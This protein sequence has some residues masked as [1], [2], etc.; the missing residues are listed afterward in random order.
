MPA[1]EIAAAER[2]SESKS[3]E[4]AASVP[5]VQT[6][7]GAGEPRLAGG[8]ADST[9]RMV[10]NVALR[11]PNAAVM[12]ASAMRQAQRSFGNRAMQEALSDKPRAAR[13]IQRSCAC[14]G[15]CDS[16]QAAAVEPV[17][18][19]QRK[20]I[21]A[22]G[23]EVDRSLIPDTPGQ[24][25][26]RNSQQLLQA[27]MG[28]D[29]S[30]VRV[31]ADARAADSAAALQA[32]AYT[33]GRDIYFGAGKYSPG[34]SEGT[35]LIAHEVTH[36]LQQSE[37]KA[38]TAPALHGS[39]M[40]GDVND[41]MEREAEQVADAV[42]ARSAMPES[43]IT[44]DGEPA[45]RRDFS[46]AGAW[47]ATGGRAWSG[48]K[49][50]A[51]AVGNAAGDLWD[52][53][54]DTAASFIDTIAPGLLPFLRDVGGA[55]FDKITS[56][57]GSLMGGLSERIKNQGV[58]GAI[59]GIFADLASSLGK[60]IGQ[61]VT[62]SCQS[63]VAAA[64][65]VVDFVKEIGGEELAELGK[66][67]KAV[68]GFFSD[69]W[70][71]LGA[72]ALDAIQKAAGTA[73]TWIKDKA[74]WV[75]DKM[76]PIRKAS[77]TAW[78]WIKRQFNIAKEE[79]AGILDWLYDKAK[80]Q[81]FKIRDKITPILGPL[82]VVAAALILLSPLGPIIVIWK[83]A[84]ILW[85]A[86]KWIWAHGI[87]PI[88]EKLRDEFR[89]HIL[90]TLISGVD[91]VTAV[92]DEASAFLCGHAGSISTGLQSLQDALAG[93][94]FL[95]LASK[96]V[97]AA[98]SF[99]GNLAGKGKCKFSDLVGEVKNVL[100]KIY[101]FVKPVL[102]ILR[103]AVLI[104]AFGA[105][106]IL[107]D[108]VWS[109]LNQFIA[110]AKKVPCVRE[111]AGLL[112]VDGAMRVVGDIR[113]N[114]KDIWEVISNQDKFEAAIHKAL[115]G[116]LAL[117][118]NKVESLA[119]EIAGLD[120]PHLH[121]LLTQ[122]LFPKIASVAGHW[123]DTL[124]SV[125]WDIVWPWPGVIK[126]ADEAEKHAGKLKTDLWDFEFNKAAD[127]GL[128]IWRD[129]NG[130]VG[131]LYG[132][133]FLAA[134][135]IGAVFASPQAG[136]AVAYEVGEA[137]LVSTL[138]AEGL[139]ILKSRQNLMADARLA[140]PSKD[141]EASD[142]EDYELMSGSVVNLAILGV[143]SVIGE[144]AVDF[145]K[146]VF[147]EIKGIFLPET[148]EAPAPETHA[149]GDAPKPDAPPTDAPTTDA[150]KTDAPQTDAPTTDAPKADAPQ[151]DAPTTDAPKTD[152]P[153][154]DAPDKA[155]D[156][157]S[158]GPDDQPTRKGK[159]EGEL[160]KRVN[161]VLDG[162]RPL[163]DLTPEE[164]RLAADYFDEVASG[165]QDSP[166]AEGSKSTAADRR[167]FNRE[168]ARFLREGTGNPPKKLFDFLKDGET[169]VPDPTP[170]DAPPSDAP[171]TDA[172]P[173]DA[174]PTDATP[175]KKP[176]TDSGE[177]QGCFVACTMVLTPGGLRRIETLT[178]GDAVICSD[179]VA[180][181]RRTCEVA[182]IMSC[183][184][185][186]VLRVSI[187]TTTIVCSAEHPFWVPGS[188]WQTA[189]K[190]TAGT[191][192]L[193]LGL[194]VVKV[195]SIQAEAGPV[196]VFN[197]SVGGPHTF[198]VSAL[199]ILVH[200]KA[201]ARGALGERVQGLKSRA[202]KAVSQAEALP[203]ETPGRGDLVDRAKNLGDQLDRLAKDTE[204][205]T[206]AEREQILEPDFTD[207]ETELG[208]LE[209]ELEAAKRKQLEDKLQD[210]Q[211]QRA[212]AEERKADF[213]KEAARQEAK[214]NELWDQSYEKH[215]AER[216]ALQD[217]AMKAGRQADIARQK[218]K[219][220]RGELEDI[221]GDLKRTDIQLNP[222]E[223]SVLPCFATGTLVW[224]PSGPRPIDSL[225]AGDMVLSQ[226]FTLGRAVPRR[227]LGIYRNQTQSFYRVNVEGTVI[228][229]TGMHRFWV[230]SLGDWVAARHLEQGMPLRL[231]SGAIASIQSI[232]AEEA[233]GAATWNLQIEDLPNYFVGPG[234]LVHNA[235]PA[236]Y[237]FGDLRIYRG[238]NPDPKFAD[239]VYIGQTDDLRRRQGEH[240]A[241]AETTL[242][243]PN[244]TPEQRE[245]Y[246]F[247]KGV[248]LDELVSG[249]S[250]PQA[251]YLEQK[252]IDIETNTQGE[253]N[254]MNRREQVDK[255]NMPD[256][257]EKIRTDPDVQD[258]GFCK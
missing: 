172:P 169:A 258:Q 72:P 195:S 162:K 93:I 134:V 246:E 92:L 97:G 245:F 50:G 116:L 80:E 139:T 128:A 103:Q 9:A 112:N 221:Y 127:D 249:L 123:K 81:W 13:T 175:A 180:V 255:K 11:H 252:N 113:A 217:R 126:D 71:D 150:P 59:A 100:K 87:K 247:M 132:W 104:A 203:A 15:T 1:S 210:L 25:L 242:K 220:V 256:L 164:A 148:A 90:P 143:M 84:P 22:S 251:D 20:P 189:G 63:M 170:S 110:F 76:L 140:M 115:D 14:G 129:V 39:V 77:A 105:L 152:A 119:G 86:L 240:R 130:I 182:S 225:A 49:S 21:G 74:T 28:E 145:A 171:P 44:S 99:F 236:R 79:G 111:M 117:I 23:G 188:G 10:S 204:G 190:L 60:A 165:I 228:L 18:L 146:A 48:V 55:L 2:E 149:P 200:N 85:N 185:S 16:C 215:G 43:G 141:R 194:G 151:T 191:P 211:D 229:A 51:S 214:A 7:P 142:H 187:G 250:K 174:A 88:G 212:D 114:L 219:G 144:L 230:E 209:E 173:T 153:Q 8:S 178:A 233:N 226:D 78:D 17:E 61:L 34:S 45:I 156:P 206:P 241:T 19:V 6:A 177:P 3:P 121:I 239:R 96:A 137:L 118:P 35:R 131:H 73:W 196:E 47:D 120:G 176:G 166:G 231:V 122:F 167:A 179:P 237:D 158:G 75:W 159:L 253:N 218:A 83:G 33:V 94:P 235:N 42:V 160:K 224:T 4:R 27:G 68:G 26:D 248:E 168:R 5:G 69:V 201:A 31:H 37:G 24:P 67:A 64:S 207:N 227:V 38:P 102:E 133:F 136:A 202:S 161:D 243:D 197:L 107:D 89:E 101:E 32:D 216:R 62:G 95:S 46:L 157:E 70:D 205:A 208:D 254:V 53:A 181:E 232:E 154:T 193:S 56:G 58:A 91:T 40:V 192:L 108:G 147:A 213:E 98:V 183:T 238:T 41:P 109:T 52:A 198:L 223:R 184:V 82:K 29:L 66:A 65:A 36:T 186:A 106:A 30:A 222:E 155:G 54:K 244:L 257:E 199:E 57:L 135:L 138:L 234:T 12:R 124:I 163:S 125:V